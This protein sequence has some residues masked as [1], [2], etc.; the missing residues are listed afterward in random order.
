MKKIKAIVLDFDG[1]LTDGTFIWGTDGQEYKRLSFYDIMGISRGLKAGLVFA[2]ISGENNSLIDRFVEKMGIID[3]YKGCKNKAEALCLFAEKH[4]FDHSQICFMG[5][6]INDLPAM[7][8][9]GFSAAPATAQEIV[10]VNAKLITK[11]AGGQ[12][13]VRELIDY[14]LA[15]NF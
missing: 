9:A 12:G 5:D 1:V 10:K 11:H 4:A 7:E 6:D 8:I 15:N 2:L 14:V 3:V 13:A